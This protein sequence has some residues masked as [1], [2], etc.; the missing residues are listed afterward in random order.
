MSVYSKT[1]EKIWT[2]KQSAGYL[3]TCCHVLDRERTNVFRSMKGSSYLRGSCPQLSSV[4]H[5]CSTADLPTIPPSVLPP[6][7]PGTVMQLCEMWYCT[8]RTWTW[9][10][11]IKLQWFDWSRPWALRLLCPCIPQWSPAVTENRA[12]A[13]AAEPA[14]WDLPHT[15]QSF[16]VARFGIIHFHSWNQKRVLSATTNTSGQWWSHRSRHWAVLAGLSAYL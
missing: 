4:W 5:P 2:W 13:E 3:H 9:S 6:H 16:A 1:E 8:G 15:H 10:S 12:H 11:E 14:C 7:R